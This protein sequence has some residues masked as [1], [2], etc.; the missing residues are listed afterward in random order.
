MDFVKYMYQN[1]VIN[2]S[3]QLKFKNIYTLWLS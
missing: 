1:T 3:F 2:E